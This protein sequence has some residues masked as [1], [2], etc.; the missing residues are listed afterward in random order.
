MAQSYRCQCW[1]A[2]CERLMSCRLHG[3]ISNLGGAFSDSCPRLDRPSE[4]WESCFGW[5]TCSST[6]CCLSMV[7]HV[8]NGEELWTMPAKRKVHKIIKNPAEQ[9]TNP[10]KS[11][12]SHNLWSPRCSLCRCW[13]LQEGTGKNRK[14]SVEMFGQRTSRRWFQGLDR[15]KLPWRHSMIHHIFCGNSS[16]CLN[17]LSQI[18][19]DRPGYDTTELWPQRRCSLDM[20]RMVDITK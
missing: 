4:I 10:I 3:T 9:P 13:N 19:A 7:H 14:W 16:F 20:F 11:L 2:A 15:F 18:H 1:Q 5:S 8:W 17:I 12:Q 6:L